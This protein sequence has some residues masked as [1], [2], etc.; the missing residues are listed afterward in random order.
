LAAANKAVTMNELDQLT[1]VFGA[2]F[3]LL[4]HITTTMH[5]RR[6]FAR[7]TILLYYVIFQNV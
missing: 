7:R 4:R 1:A 6:N 2:T 5:C 3:R